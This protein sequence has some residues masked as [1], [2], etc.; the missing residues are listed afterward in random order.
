VYLPLNN[1][2]LNCILW[3]STDLTLLPSY[4]VRRP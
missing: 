3:P 4:I 1:N 2:R